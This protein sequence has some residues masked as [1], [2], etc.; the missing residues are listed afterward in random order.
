MQSYSW[1]EFSDATPADSSDYDVIIF[2][3]DG[4]YII[5]DSAT[6]AVIPTG[7]T[8]ILR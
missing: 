8:L 4:S 1:L 7:T 5:S 3:E 2:A 6:L